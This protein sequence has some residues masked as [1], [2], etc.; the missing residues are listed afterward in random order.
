MALHATAKKRITILIVIVLLI[1]GTIGALWFYRQNENQERIDQLHAQAEQYYNEGDYRQ[2]LDPMRSYVRSN[3]NDLEAKYALADIYENV[4]QPGGRNIAA[5]I[6]TLRQI[7]DSDPSYKDTAT[8]LL[9]YYVQFQQN[10]EAVRLINDILKRKPT[11]V[12]ALQ[13][14]AIIDSRLRKFEEALVSVNKVLEQ[15][16]KNFRMELLKAEIQQQLDT[17]SETI[18]Q[19]AEELAK[20]NPDDPRY[21]L[22]LAYAYRNAQDQQKS[23]EY[24]QKASDNPPADT[25]YINTLVRFLDG[26]GEFN[27]SIEVLQKAVPELNDPILH[28]AL[29]VRLM[30]VA[31]YND[32]LELIGDIKPDSPASSLRMIM[33]QTIAY[34]YTNQKDQ[35]NINIEALNNRQNN[36]S[37]TTLGIALKDV[38]NVD[39]SQPEKTIVAI[40]EALKHHPNY[41]YLYLY[42][43]DTYGQ[44]QDNENAIDAW[45]NAARLRPTWAQPLAQLALAYLAQGKTPEAQVLATAAAQ[46]NQNN[47]AIAATWALTAAANIKPDQKEAAKDILNVI[48]QLENRGVQGSQLL[49]MQLTLLEKTGNRDQA[50]TVIEDTLKSDSDD[51]TQET[52]LSM[53]TLSRAMR[54]DLADQI[55]D[56]VQSKF[57][58]TPQLALAR[59]TYLTSQGKNEQAQQYMQT[60]HDQHSA[61]KTL[62]WDV[63]QATYYRIINDPRSQQAWEKIAED[64]PDNSRAQQLALRA[65]ASDP[66]ALQ[67]NEETLDRLE[68]IAGTDN[69]NVKTERARL[70]LSENNPNRNPEGAIKILETVIQETP[71]RI[72]PR[73]MIAQAYEETGRVPLAMRELSNISKNNPDNP[74]VALELARLYQSVKSFNSSSDQLDIVRKSPVATTAQLSRAARLYA[75]QGE[76]RLALAAL[77]RI[78]SELGQLPNND[79]LLAAELYRRTDQQNKLTPLINEMLTSPS[80]RAIAWAADYF[81]STGNQ[82]RADQLITQL[83][84]SNLDDGLIE[85]LLAS[86]SARHGSIDD[87][88][89]YDIQRTE[90]QPNNPDAW[91]QLI[92][93]Y[94][95]NN[96]TDDAI[97][98]A[99]KGLANINKQVAL[100]AI[101][102]HENAIKKFSNQPLYKPIILGLLG[103][104]ESREVS[105]KVLSELSIADTKEMKASDFAELI[106]PIA[107]KHTT[108]ITVQNLLSELYLVTG[109][110]E[111]AL[112]VADRTAVN[113]PQSPTAVRISTDA[114]MAL[115]EWNDAIIS[116]NQWKARNP[117]ASLLA[118]LRIA[119]AQL[120]INQPYNAI[121]TLNPYIEQA[122]AQPNE[123]PQIISL[124][125]RA[126]SLDNRITQ[127]IDLYTPL[128]QINPNWRIDALRNA[129]L[130]TK[131]P[132]AIVAWV[133]NISQQIP[134][135]ELEQRSVLAES[136]WDIGSKFDINEIKEQASSLIDNIVTYD[137]AP[138][139]AWF[140]RGVIK[141]TNGNLADASSSYRE[142]IKLNP[143][144][145]AAK[146]NLAFI[147]IQQSQANK[148]AATLAE[149]AV[150]ASPSNPSFLDTLATVQSANK[151]YNK[152]I[153][154]QKRAIALDPNNPLWRVNLLKIYEQ[155]GFEQ[156]ANELKHELETRG[157]QVPP[158]S[159]TQK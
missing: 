139:S 25:E 105:D 95:A 114:H 148:E 13:A 135:A 117:E 110:Y 103:S 81:A 123:F 7:V 121:R 88:L 75:S 20:Q 56:K 62:D 40:K 137:N 131:N 155:A 43:G 133:D 107:D 144:F 106:R 63:A 66:N 118:S 124:Y 6:G 109:S 153:E 128:F 22:L 58:M 125:G 134:P 111:N 87:A 76:D 15:D 18:I 8:R 53:A 65:L 102:T 112:E 1:G 74:R 28:E 2:A 59:A 47:P 143:D 89:N 48:K 54:L 93:R 132:K 60:Q 91:K 52:L 119:A 146:N 100:Q 38:F 14:Q 57:G 27:T 24:L 156:D 41:A 99:Q 36:P 30:E 26:F 31:R 84:Q 108:V 72:E 55:Y 85:Q 157:I 129:T 46:R 94:L 127:A 12:D 17:P 33:Y 45:Q 136:L 145:A 37:A 115:G 4:P 142:A 154:T 42:L 98:A 32:A 80:P 71:D 23:I 68:K 141:E 50:R 34:E 96:D 49:L 78:D 97:A 101:I 77:D 86:Y 51:I 113:F 73:L 35:A 120:Q 116:A 61:S 158:P 21:N 29:I 39:N 152:A 79:Q 9:D 3:P 44:I 11:N 16:P 104:A 151:N 64:Y 10:D 92:A 126:L 82:S 150:N 19:E 149:Q 140:V 130:A 5:A 67:A 122:K 70:L 138:A 69:I 147:L 159:T 83:K 90:K